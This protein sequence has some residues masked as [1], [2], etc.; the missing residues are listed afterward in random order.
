MPLQSCI[1]DISRGWFNVPPKF[2]KFIAAGL[3]KREFPKSSLVKVLLSLFEMKTYH[4]LLLFTAFI[5]EGQAR[6][7]RLPRLSPE[8]GFTKS[9]PKLNL[10]T[11]AFSEFT[12][13]PY[14]LPFSLNMCRSTG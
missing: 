12:V 7:P 4:L 2:P 6:L 11:V 3:F 5:P 8:G 10:V 13:N 14:Q 1:I 9:A